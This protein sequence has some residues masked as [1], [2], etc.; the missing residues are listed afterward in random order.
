MGHIL[1]AQNFS[2]EHRVSVTTLSWA[3]SVLEYSFGERKAGLAST[4][5]QLSLAKIITES[6][7][8]IASSRKRTEN[9]DTC[10]ICTWLKNS[11]FR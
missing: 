9:R 8:S 4:P 6:L 3:H 10:G 7:S 1:A 2:Y 5:V 11:V